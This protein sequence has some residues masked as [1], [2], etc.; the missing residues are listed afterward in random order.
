MYLQNDQPLHCVAER[1][2]FVVLQLCSLAVCQKHGCVVRLPA[3]NRLW[4]S[5][6][7][8]N[9]NGLTN[10]HIYRKSFEVLI[11]GDEEAGVHGGDKEVEEIVMF[12]KDN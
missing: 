10:T 7:A 6:L 1:D 9:I 2:I 11:E 12:S 5:S 8:D 3:G 4:S